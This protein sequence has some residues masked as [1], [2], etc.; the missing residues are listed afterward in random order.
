[1]HEHGILRLL[2]KINFRPRELKTGRLY[3]GRSIFDQQDRQPVRRNLV[4]FRHHHAEAVRINKTR[5][6]PALAG[7][8][9]QLSHVNFAGRQQH[10]LDA[11][12]RKVTIH[13]RCR[14]SVVGAQGLDL[15]NRRVVGA[16]VPQADI[17]EQR[18]VLDRIDG[19]FPDGRRKRTFRSLPIQTESNRSCLNVTFDIRPFDRNFIWPHINS[20]DDSR[21]SQLQNKKRYHRDG[22]FFIL[23]HPNQRQR[24]QRDDN[25]QPAQRQ[26]D[27][28]IHIIGAGHEGV[29]IQQ[30]FIVAE[31]NPNRESKQ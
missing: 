21:Q 25:E 3:F 2:A 6:D 5:I 18:G 11:A 12:I 31:K 20:V 13:V 1:M 15:T 22:S 17:I 26:R 10:L 4:D 28:F 29:R 30:Q 8:R 24:S 19:R 16:Q 9:R 14:K 27:F 7:F 23:P